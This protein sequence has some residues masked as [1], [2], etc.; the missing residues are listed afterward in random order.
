MASKAVNR[1]MNPQLR[2]QDINRKLQLYG[3]MQ[4]TWNATVDHDMRR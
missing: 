4:G 3:I 1:P 2:D